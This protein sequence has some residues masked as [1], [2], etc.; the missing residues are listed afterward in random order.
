MSIIQFSH[1]NGFPAKTYTALFDHLKEHKISAIN[2]LGEN[3]NPNEINWY[4][5][6]DDVLE[7][8][9]QQGEAVI[10][11]GHSFGGVLTLLAA[12][13]KPELFQSIIL[14]DPPLFSVQKSALIKLLRALNIEDWV[15]PSGKSKKRRD[16]FESKSQAKTLF[17]ANKLF[18]NF[19]PQTLNDYV[20]HGLTETDNGVELTI[21]VAKEVAI[22]HKSLTSFPKNIYKVKGTLVYAAKNPILWPSDLRWINRKFA[23]L[24]VIPFPGSHLFPLENPQSTALMIKRCL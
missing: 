18:K 2:I 17:Q 24:Q 3:T 12:A 19:H 21:P 4:D 9:E 20:T 11:I 8:I 16:H 5:M 10:G 22:F 13:K 14:L 15:S 7:S 6:R 23:Y 1:A